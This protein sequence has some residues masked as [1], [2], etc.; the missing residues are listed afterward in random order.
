MKVGAT[1]RELMA[2]S[3]SPADRLL[4]AEEVAEMLAVPTSW[5][6]EATR[7]GQLPHVRLGRYVRYDR[8]AILAWVSEQQPG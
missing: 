3:G 1:D 2:A 4:V 8:G 7:S 5:V 6:R